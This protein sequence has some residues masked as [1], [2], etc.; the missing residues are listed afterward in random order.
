M[1]KEIYDYIKIYNINKNNK[2][3]VLKIICRDDNMYIF[4]DNNMIYTCSYN[5]TCSY[6]FNIFEFILISDNLMSFVENCYIYFY[7]VDEII[8]NNFTLSKIMKKIQIYNTE[9]PKFCDINKNICK[10]TDIMSCEK[11]YFIDNKYIIVTNSDEFG[12]LM[13]I[14]N[15]ILFTTKKIELHNCQYF[16]SEY[17]NNIILLDNKKEML[18]NV[19]SYDGN[20]NYICTII[21]DDVIFNICCSNDSKFVCYINNSFFGTYIKI[22]NIETST[23]QSHK[24]HDILEPKNTY[25]NIHTVSTLSNYYVI[26]IYDNNNTTMYYYIFDLSCKII[27]YQLDLHNKIMSFELT[28]FTV[29]IMDKLT[30]NIKY[31]IYINILNKIYNDN[32]KSKKINVKINDNIYTIH[33]TIYELLNIAELSNYETFI[34]VI[35]ND[36]LPINKKNIA[37]SNVYGTDTSVEEDIDTNTNVDETVVADCNILLMNNDFKFIVEI[38]ILKLFVITKNKLFITKFEFKYFDIVVK[39]FPNSV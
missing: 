5:N 16:L 22:Y 19:F 32:I 35:Y 9:I 17:C 18:I 13:L 30:V 1:D 28:T 33:K 2:I 8:N 36:K 21:S 26:F 11:C 39:Q 3:Y 25:I 12:R 4:I 6:Q 14:N 31:D 20:I 27:D 7:D 37:E 38:I 34:S 23:W 29:Q 10:T 15:L 24:I